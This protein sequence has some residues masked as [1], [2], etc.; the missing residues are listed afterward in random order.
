MIG[1]Y[2]LFWF[3][4]P[5]LA[6][7][8]AAIRKKVYKK[9]VGELAAHQISTLTL[10]ILIGIYTWLI[11][12]GWKLE[13]TGQA[14]IV[15]TI[16]IA[17]T[18]SFELIFGRFVMKNPWKRLLHDYNIFKGRVW[19]LMLLWTLIVPLVVNYIYL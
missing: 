13:S 15:G 8:N 2:V 1:V 18:V 17:L 14:F 5:I 11:S 12:I 6:I 10:I 16:W 19:I 3:G 7:L 9:S 4:M